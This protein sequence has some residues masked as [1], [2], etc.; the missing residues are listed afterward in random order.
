MRHR[1]DRERL[2]A[3]TAEERQARLARRRVQDRS[4]AAR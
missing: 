3:E 1:V 2:D 4:Y